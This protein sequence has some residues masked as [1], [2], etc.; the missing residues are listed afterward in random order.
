MPSTYSQ[1]RAG[2]TLM[3]VAVATVITGVVLV[4]A[5]DAVG[6]ALRGARSSSDLIDGHTLAEQLMA[7]ILA[8]P[9]EDPDGN[10]VGIGIEPDEPSTPSD[11]L[12]FDDVDD[13]DGY[14]EASATRA[15]GT[16]LSAGAGWQR[17]A[18]VWYVDGDV[19]TG[20]LTIVTSDEGVLR[21]RVRCTSAAG[22]VVNVWALRSRYGPTSGAIPFDATVASAVSVELS[23]GGAAVQKG[24]SLANQPEAP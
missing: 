24:I 14:T 7:E 6:T 17:A 13:Y 16:N 15:D 18:W 10:S 2:V 1:R 8:L 11:R 12:A 21:V 9:Y 5:L 19:E 3:E 23:T 22:E 20:G 4:T